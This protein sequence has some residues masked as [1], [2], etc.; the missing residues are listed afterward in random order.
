MLPAAGAILPADASDAIT[1]RGG[2]SRPGGGPTFDAGQRWRWALG[3]DGALT[4][5]WRARRARTV[6]LTALAGDGEV[7]RSTLAGVDVMR[8]D[9]TRTGYALLVG[10]RRTT[11]TRV[12]RDVGAS[13]YDARLRA[14]ELSARVPAGASVTVRIRALGRPP[15]A[16][17]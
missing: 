8:A 11:L 6:V 5:S 1:I 13:A 3:R 14:F 4:I 17:G 16:G 2:W 7:A 10:G 12:R 15:V 9:G